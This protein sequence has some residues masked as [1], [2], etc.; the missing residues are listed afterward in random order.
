M[1]GRD[2][3]GGITRKSGFGTIARQANAAAGGPLLAPDEL[4]DEIPF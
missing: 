1:I 2:L 4:N 3:G